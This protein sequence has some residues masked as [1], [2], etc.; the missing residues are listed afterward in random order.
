MSIKNG[1]CDWCDR[2]RL[3]E[4]GDERSRIQFGKLWCGTCRAGSEERYRG[5]DTEFLT[6]QIEI[7]EE[8]LAQHPI[9]YEP[10]YD[11]IRM[12]LFKLDYQDEAGR[13]RR[14]IGYRLDA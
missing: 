14:E 8:M 12:H 5:R 4:T 10:P 11:H 1:E 7:M 6:G 9:R 3:L 13:M 2:G